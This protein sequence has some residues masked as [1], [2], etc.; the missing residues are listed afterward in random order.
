MKSDDIKV[1]VDILDEYKGT[2]DKSTFFWLFIT[3]KLYQ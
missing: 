2:L 1:I 3:I